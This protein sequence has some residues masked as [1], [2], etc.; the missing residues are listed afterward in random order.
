MV[1]DLSVFHEF[2]TTLSGKSGENVSWKASLNFSNMLGWWDDTSFGDGN[3]QNAGFN[4]DSDHDASMW[5]DELS[6]TFDTSL[7]GQG[8][9]ATAGRFRHSSGAMFLSRPDYTEFYANDRWD[10]GQFSIDGA[11]LNFGFG[12]VDL[13]MFGGLVGEGLET[14][15]GSAFELN[16]MMRDLGDDEFN[17]ESILG[18]ELGAKLGENANLRGVYIFQD[19]WDVDS[20]MNR[21][22]TYGGEVNF[23][24]SGLDI[25]GAYA[26]TDFGYN[27]DVMLDDDNAAW[28][29]WL[30]YAQGERWGFD[31]GYARVEGNFGAF[32]SWGRLGT[33]YNP[34]NIEGFGGGV[35]FRFNDRVKLT[36]GMASFDGAEDTFGLFGLP[37][38]TDD[39][40]TSFHVGLDFALNQ[41]WDLKFGYENV[42]WKFDADT[43]PNMRWYTIGLSHD[44]SDAAKFSIMYLMSDVD[45]NGSIAGGSLDPFG[46]GLYK[47]G[48]LSSQLSFRF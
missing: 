46:A 15:S 38:T 13:T 42:D 20:G 29:A 12:S 31:A 25:Y 2:N 24:V 37:L 39:T 41:A 34:T 21:M 32:G 35:W 23:K 14:I 11:R 27:T 45:F 30:S 17:V 4:I 8:F 22:T 26:K 44:L 3:S 19:S 40:V 9:T 18:F 10:N 6:A 16:S 48:A 47:G 43:D 7:A 33:Q 5:F 1:Q 36:A 28:A